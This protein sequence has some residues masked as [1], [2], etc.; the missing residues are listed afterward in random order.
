M[1]HLLGRATW[2]IRARMTV[3]A[4]LAAVVL[5]VVTAWLVLH[6]RHDD[7]L[8]HRFR[9]VYGANLELVHRFAHRAV[10]PVIEV[11]DVSGAQ[12]V[13][14][15]GQVVSATARMLG[16]PRMAAFV[17]AP[18]SASLDRTLCDV[19]AFPRQCMIVAAMWVPAPDGD[20]V[21]YSALPK[22]PWYLSEVL[23]AQLVTGSL[24]LLGLVALGTYQLVGRT[25]RPVEAM[26][27]ELAEITAT[28]LG[29]RVPVPGHHDEIRYL[30]T[31]VNDTLELL[32]A[33][34]RRERRFTSD[35]SH[36]LRAPLT[37]ARLRLEEALMDPG[38]V[39][40]PCMAKELLCDVERQQAIAEDILTLARLNA[41]RSP[42]HERTDLTELTRAELR[43]RLPG[44][45]PV[46]TDL[47]PGVF[48]ACDRLL[49]GRLLTNLL[50]NAQ[51]HAAT[52][53][54]VVVRAEDDTAVLAV[55]DD[56]GGI[57]PK[58]REIVFERFARLPE[59][60]ARDPKG[61]GLGLAICREI[62]QTHRGSL[63]VE[64]PGRGTCL[65]LRL[66][67]QPD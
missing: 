32:E 67:L 27:A 55:G 66:P 29:H 35:A 7:E 40:W 23:L 60:R 20:L 39:D 18:R 46:R 34:L 64:D 51:R 57:A 10:P 5:C 38:G 53:V 16:Q 17:P 63:A 15:D 49:M 6:H 21:A 9:H 2:S 62:A 37:G 50:D 52:V 3:L 14:P 31:V 43:R 25:L 33:A 42:Q 28:D 56:G 54:T 47:E 36:D 48:V 26:T 41:D 58:H 22:P 4:T 13:K 11:R 45:V 44:R 19:P 1:S 8:E 30:A 24:I 61:T 65:V 59:S 12:L